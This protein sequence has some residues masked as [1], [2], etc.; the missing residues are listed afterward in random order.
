[1]VCS[2][3]AYCFMTQSIRSSLPRV[4]YWLREYTQGGADDRRAAEQFVESETRETVQALQAELQVLLLADQPD[5]R[6]DRVIGV[7]RRIKHGSYANW[8][9][10]MLQWLIEK[11][12]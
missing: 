10:L 4:R 1:M 6:L 11:K 2:K 9:S 5:D 7:K 3:G 12:Q 8:A